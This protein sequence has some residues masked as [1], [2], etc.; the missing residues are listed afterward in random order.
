MPQE[1]AIFG[2]L[3]VRLSE[4]RARRVWEKRR[5]REECCREPDASRVYMRLISLRHWRISFDVRTSPTLTTRRARYRSAAALVLAVISLGIFL[6]RDLSAPEPAVSTQPGAAVN[7]ITM[8]EEFFFALDVV[9]FTVQ[10]LHSMI[11]W[12]ASTSLHSTKP[13]APIRPLTTSSSPAPWEV[14]QSCSTAS[15]SEWR[16]H[17]S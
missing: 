15:P 16:P 7:P 13:Q 11:R 17:P 2:K 12:A 10:S 1:A 5:I 4:I 8:V 3:S 14:G 9:M 6:V